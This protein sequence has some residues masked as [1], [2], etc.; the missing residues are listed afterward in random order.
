MR[1][2]RR[3]KAILYNK[4]AKSFDTQ[5]NLDLKFS[6]CEGVALCLLNN[7]KYKLS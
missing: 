4:K 1:S 7:L 5:R 3:R 2:Q 6:L